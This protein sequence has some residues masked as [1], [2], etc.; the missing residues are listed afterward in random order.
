[1][2]LKVW[3]FCTFI[4]LGGFIGFLLL[5]LQTAELWKAATI[6]ACCV[7]MGAAITAYFFTRPGYLKKLT[8]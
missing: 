7:F 6:K 8:N 2:T 4:S 1:M 3:L 5:E